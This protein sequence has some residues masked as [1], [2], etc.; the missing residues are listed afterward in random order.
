VVFSRTLPDVH[1]TNTRLKSE[2]IKEEIQEL[3]HQ[4]GKDIVVGS[5]GLIIAFLKLN[6]VDELQL[7]IHPVLAGAGMR[8]FQNIN[9]QV[10]LKLLQTKTFGCGAVILYYEPMG[11]DLSNGND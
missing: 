5:P 3:K 10:P 4:P 1:W 11:F 2:L 8:L 6:L 7:C 9:G